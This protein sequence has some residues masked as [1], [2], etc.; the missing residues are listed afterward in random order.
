MQHIVLITTKQPSSN[1]RLLKEA[2]VLY[3]AGF[4]VTVVY[5]FW[6]NWAQLADEAIFKK[7]PSINWLNVSPTVSNFYFFK[8]WYTRV[9]FKICRI[10]ATLFKKCISLQAMASTQF[11]PELKKK[12]TQLQADLYIGHNIGALPAAANAAK[13]NK[14]KYAFDA[15]DFHRSIDESNIEEGRIAIVLENKY[16]NHSAYISA[17][18]FL[19][20]AEY[21]KH[22]ANKTFIVINNVLSVTQQPLFCYL[23]HSTL[24]LFWFSQTVGLKRGIQDVIYAINNIQEFPIQFSILGDASDLI[25]SKL[26]SLLINTKHSIQFISPCNEDKLITFAATQHIGLALEPGFSL[27]NKIALSNKLF[28]YLLVGNAVI[29]SNTP[30]QLLYYKNYPNTAWCYTSG[31]IKELKEIIMQAGN[32]EALLTSKRKSA[33]HIAKTTLNWEMEQQL[34]LK[35]IKEV[36]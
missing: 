21:K 24:R 11:Y 31:N 26:H 12:A 14:T 30:S 34:F 4:K 15:E 6:S 8:Y 16:F 22:Y 1:P 23:P 3:N 29:L 19:I 2:I 5:N 20:A 27:N 7:Y 36:I 32:N 35:L 10:L 18:S 17:A 28:T 25:K 9:R 33:W 13:K